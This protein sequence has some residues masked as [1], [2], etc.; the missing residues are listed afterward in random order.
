MNETDQANTAAQAF[1]P[2]I[3]DFPDHEFAGVYR[4]LALD[5]LSVLAA[6]IAERGMLEPVILYED[7][8]LDG[9][10]RA[11]CCDPAETFVGRSTRPGFEERLE[12][13]GRLVHGGRPGYVVFE[14]TDGEARALVRS[15]NDKR[16]HLTA[17]ERLAG[18]KAENP[19][20]FAPGGSEG[21]TKGGRPKK[22]DSNIPFS[23][24]SAPKTDAEIA[25]EVGV[26]VPSV[27]QYRA[28]QTKV[29]PVAPEIADAVDEGKVSVAAASRIASVAESEPDTVREA[30][31]AII[32][33]KNPIDAVHAVRWRGRDPLAYIASSKRDDWET[34]PEVFDPLHAAFDFTIDV[35]ASELN[36][37]VPRYWSDA[38]A[39][40]WTGERCWCNPPYGQAQV[41]FIEEAAKREAELV[42]LL[43]PA[44]T[45]TAAWH[46]LI[47]PR[48]EVWFLRG[49]ISFVGAGPA[50]FPAA[51]ALFRPTDERLVVRTGKLDDILAGLD[52]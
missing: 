48:A 7:E 31:P 51:L 13:G 21:K 38:F 45:D 16:R 15:L 3:P 44:R 52:A 34:P 23:D 29:R 11:R 19:E 8:I 20:E 18:R 6:D 5:E 9:R 32:E 40:P 43:I 1:V 22:R 35:A 24:G 25:A 36:R 46:D 10:N 42:A 2:R 12:T 41:R 30:V 33:G 28:V 37:R 17:G 47:F 4:L 14:G 50:P 26:S 39:Q 27:K 49:R